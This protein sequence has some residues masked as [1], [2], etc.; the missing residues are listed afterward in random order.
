LIGGDFDG[1]W[2]YVVGPLAGAAVAWVLWR[3]FG[4]DEETAA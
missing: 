2:I 4:G 3:M 1:F